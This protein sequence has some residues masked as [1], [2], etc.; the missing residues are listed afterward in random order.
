MRAGFGVFK[1]TPFHCSTQPLSLRV[2]AHDRERSV[3][4]RSYTDV[5][6]FNWKRNGSTLFSFTV[7]GVVLRCHF[8]LRFGKYTL[9]KNGCNVIVAVK[10]RKLFLSALKFTETHARH[11]SSLYD[12]STFARRCDFTGTQ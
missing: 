5:R 10:L 1:I 11:A 2:F 12:K 7:V 4:R 3:L 9:L 8:L 6:R